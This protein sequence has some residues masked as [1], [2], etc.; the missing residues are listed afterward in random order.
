M[1]EPD[2]MSTTQIVVGPVPNHLNREKRRNN[3]PKRNG[4]CV[5]VGEEGC[6]LKGAK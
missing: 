6:F 5:V 3:F 2:H 4:L 1:A